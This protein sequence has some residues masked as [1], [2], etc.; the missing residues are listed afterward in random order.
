MPATGA[1][2]AARAPSGDVGTTSAGGL[3]GQRGLGSAST[4]C[5]RGDIASLG[6][7]DPDRVARTGAQI[8]MLEVAPQPSDLDA[9]DRVVLRIEA[10]V[11]AEHRNGEVKGLQAMAAAGQRLLDNVG[12]ERPAARAGAEIRR[13]E[14]PSQIVPDIVG[15][16]GSCLPAAA[17][18]PSSAPRS[19][20]TAT[21]TDMSFETRLIPHRAAWVST[22]FRHPCYRNILPRDQDRAQTS[23]VASL[24]A[25]RFPPQLNR[26]RD[27]CL[28]EEWWREDVV[29]EGS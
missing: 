13:S 15:R 20:A 16:R 6:D 18:S 21:V 25:E 14:K 24:A 19:M 22:N 28:T 27:M 9:N 8:V 23:K 5:E 2:D 12:E 4:T 3:R 10:L 26:R 7:G 11:T 29:R 1:V 17:I